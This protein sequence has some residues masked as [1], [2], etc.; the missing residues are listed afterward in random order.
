MKGLVL[1]SVFTVV[2]L[3]AAMLGLSCARNHDLEFI[4]I[5]PQQQTLGIACVTPGVP[6]SCAPSTTYRAIGHYIHPQTQRDITS[7]VQWTTGNRDLITFA[8]PSQPNV[9][10]PTGVGCGTNLL[11]QATLNSDPGNVKI[12]S[13]TVNINC[14]GSLIGGGNTTDFAL[15]P[16]PRQ[17]TVSAG[18]STTYTIQVTAL[19]DTP[20]VQ[21]SVN[22]STLPSGITASLAPP[23]V[24]G[25]QNSILTLSASSTIA[26]GPHLVQVQG[27]DLSGSVATQVELDVQ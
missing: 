21:L 12:A 18:G 3:G 8:D 20:T 27:A 7:E 5:T 1:R 9:L 4:S 11:V 26:T 13:A 22:Q 14:T 6:T 10:F 23:T 17:Q 16:I 19:I 25:S 24:T 15:T 2:V